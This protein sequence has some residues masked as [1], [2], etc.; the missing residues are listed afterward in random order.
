MAE[1]QKTPELAA[2]G[3]PQKW[4]T[5]PGSKG[6]YVRSGVYDRETGL[7]LERWPVD[8]KELLAADPGRYS[9]DPWPDD[10]KVEEAAVK[11]FEEHLAAH[12]PKAASIVPVVDSK[13]LDEFTKP[14]LVA[15][16]VSLK[17]DTSGNK[18]DLVE[19]IKAAQGI[20]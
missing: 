6:Y 5:V 19:R 15:L 12:D 20:E 8:V 18:P 16:A 11:L 3:S 13:P 14:E 17:L 7:F 9:R 1:A 10:P 4:V 2:S